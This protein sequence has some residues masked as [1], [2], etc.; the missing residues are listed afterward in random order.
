[1]KD[2]L[3]LRPIAILDFMDKEIEVLHPQLSVM[4]GDNSASNGKRYL[5]FGSLCY[6]RR[7][8][9]I[10][11]PQ[12]N[13]TGSEVD[14]STLEIQ[15]VFLTRHLIELARQKQNFTTAV[16]LFNATKVF[17]DWIDDQENKYS[18]DK[19][20]SMTEA[21]RGYTRYLLH[22]IN[23]SGIRANPL[24]QSSASSRQTAARIVVTIATGLHEREVTALA[25]YIPRRHDLGHINLNQPNSDIQARTFSALVNFIEEA[26]RLLVNEGGIPMRLI[27][28]GNEPFFLYSCNQI[29]KKSN[30]AGFSI[31]QML[32]SRSEFPTWEEVKKHFNLSGNSRA[33]KRE[34]SNYEIAKIANKRKNLEARCDLRLQIGNHAMCAGMLAF[35][36][37][38]GANYC[39]TQTL[40]MDT[41]E[42]VPSTQGQRFSGTKS[43]A[44]GKTVYPEFGVQ[45]VPIFRKILELREWVLNGKKSDLVFMVAPR[46]SNSISFIGQ[47]NITALKSL[48]LKYQ[49]ATRW[50]A[51]RQ[52]RKNV[53]YQYI[54]I[55][56]GDFQLTAEKLGNTERTLQIN[57]SRPA[58]EEFSAQM[59]GFFDAM[60][61][62][63]V[64]RT[65]TLKS[66]PVLVTDTK[67]PETVTGIGSCKN[68]SLAEP[69][70]A[71]GFTQ[72]APKPSC[73]DPETCL[74]CRFY[75]V[76]A[77]DDDIRRLFS[78]RYLITAINGQQPHDH[79]ITKFGPTIHRIDEVL[80]AIKEKNSNIE[81]TISRIRDEVES[82]A[83][84][85]FW[86]IHFDTLVYVGAVS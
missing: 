29:T 28:P 48:L 55:S 56:G 43:R 60:Y 85:P 37:A 69:L 58:L 54:G 4:V 9:P 49:P 11:N 76:H 62:A 68:G 33:I 40:E 61:S 79:W 8:V 7:K 41:S 66:I 42:I 19:I 39:I 45:F 20:E 83:L 70:R 65:R 32:N 14:L 82:G 35:I 67:Q 51:P 78:L 59:S 10:R 3:S 86:A 13:Y 31:N 50:I 27:S 44:N 24:K 25:T 52:W 47:C 36:A 46:N 26:H 12:K 34:Q 64:D 2:N 81:K 21:Y 18:F 63:A 84:D 53:S 6:S 5:D 16:Q 1:M 77:D 75:A 22:K 57:Y 73:G 23:D 71:P 80:I 30:S 74:F 38:T 15:R 72:M 17:I